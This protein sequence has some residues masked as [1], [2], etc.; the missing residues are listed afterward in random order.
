[1]GKDDRGCRGELCRI[2]QVCLQMLVPHRFD[3]SSASLVSLDRGL[4]LAWRTWLFLEGSHFGRANLDD[5][6]QRFAV[7]I[8]GGL[9]N[10]QLLLQSGILDIDDLDVLD[11][12]VGFRGQPGGGVVRAVQGDVFG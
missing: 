3:G 4:G 10:R 7:G 8:P 11:L 5:G 12:R 6:H 1:M 2:I 9:R